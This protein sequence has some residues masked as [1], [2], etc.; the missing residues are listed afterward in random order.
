MSDNV[1]H[2]DVDAELA[3]ALSDMQHALVERDA[4]LARRTQAE[5]DAEPAADF[6]AP[7]D[8]A[9]GATTSGPQDLDELKTL[10]T[11]LAETVKELSGNVDKQLTRC[12]ELYKKA[13]DQHARQDN[14]TSAV[15]QLVRNTAS[16]REQVR[17]LT[18]VPVPVPSPE[19]TLPL[20][21]PVPGRQHS[22]AIS[23]KDVI[24]SL[25]SFYGNTNKTA[26]VL[27]PEDF[28]RCCQWFDSVKWKLFAAGVPQHKHVPIVCQ[29]LQ[30][31]ALKAFMSRS[32]AEQ[33]DV[34]ACDMDQLRERLLSLFVEAEAQYTQKLIDMKFSPTDL[35]QNMQMFRLY[36]SY[37]SFA[38][39]CDRNAYLYQLVREKMNRAVPS[40]LVTAQTE[41]QLTLDATSSFKKF[42]DDAITIAHRI[43][44]NVVKSNVPA[45][46]EKRGAPAP[47]AQST[48]QARTNTAM[49][50]QSYGAA[51]YKIMANDRPQVLL[52]RFKRC[53][54]CAFFPKN[55]SMAQQ[56]AVTTGG[57]E[58][59]ARRGRR[60]ERP[61][62][63]YPFPR[64]LHNISR[65]GQ[66]APHRARV[67]PQH[68]LSALGGVPECTQGKLVLVAR[69]GLR[70]LPA[71]LF[72]AMA[73]PS[74]TS[75]CN[76]QMSSLYSVFVAPRAFARGGT[77]CAASASVT[78]WHT[79]A[80]GT[81]QLQPIQQ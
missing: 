45:P 34:P 13:A 71:S 73:T 40:C 38:L 35:A 3:S 52:D 22:D 43:Q 50:T 68:R 19:G 47:A 41:H 4:D 60:E 44:A 5:L 27:D 30:G 2:R 8:P 21:L 14:L 39:S 42:M 20:P 66:P 74:A 77:A 63:P 67:S 59:V 29:K 48:K 58:R 55:V 26:E 49:S 51:A 18:S 70:G 31:P 46:G 79:S 9:S 11:S 1:S 12:D 15:T 56:R 81:A 23:A 69:H 61:F 28:L 25:D 62:N 64:N 24:A 10:V 72:S 7:A 78:G 75:Q 33:W 80:G 65:A 17:T 36:V 16:L 6:S 76:S 57:R 37:S 32:T 53:H 54:T